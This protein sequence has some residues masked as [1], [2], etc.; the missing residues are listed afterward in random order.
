MQIDVTDAAPFPPLIASPGADP[1]AV[2][3]LRG[4]LLTAG[5]NPRT[6]RLLDE[7]LIQD[8][9]EQDPTAYERQKMWAEAA[10]RAGYDHP[11]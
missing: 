1:G 10:R 11:F 6:R 5:R 9:R 3:A 4:A 7:L 8:F 2:A